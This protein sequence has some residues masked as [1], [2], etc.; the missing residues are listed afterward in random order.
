MEVALIVFAECAKLFFQVECAI[1]LG[2][3][4]IDYL[5]KKNN[6]KKVSNYED[7]I[8]VDDKG[9]RDNLDKI[10]EKKLS[11]SKNEELINECARRIINYLPESDRKNLCNNFDTLDIEH[12]P[13]QV[14][15]GLGGGYYIYG[16][17]IEYSNRVSLG[18]EMLYYV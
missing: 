13:F 8:L 18:H 6:L 3:L 12:K 9:I 16:N 11:F 7:W 17:K 5:S 15:L 1:S 14:L 4:S 2:A 10:K